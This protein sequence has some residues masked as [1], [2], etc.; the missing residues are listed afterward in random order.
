MKTEFIEKWANRK[1]VGKM[2][3]YGWG[4]FEFSCFMNFSAVYNNTEVLSTYATSVN[5]TQRTALH[6]A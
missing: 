4:G 1:N 6:N 5:D 3:K 2:G